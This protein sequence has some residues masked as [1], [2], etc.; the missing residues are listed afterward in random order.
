MPQHLEGDWCAALIFR[1]PV[2]SPSDELYLCSAGFRTGCNVGLQTHVC[3]WMY[4][5]SM[6]PRVSPLDSS[7]L[8]GIAPPRFG[9]VHIRNRGRLPHWEKEAGLYFLTFHLA[10]SLP[11]EVLRKIAERHEI[12]AEAKRINARLL[13]EQEAQ[14]AEYSRRRIEEYVDRGYGSAILADPR[15]AGATTATLRYWADKR[16]RLLAWCVMPNYVHVV[17][18]LFP[19]YELGTIVKGWKH[20]VSKAVNHALGQS[21]KLWQREYYDHLI[22]DGE[23]RKRAIQYVIEN[24]TKAGLKNWSWVCGADQEAGPKKDQ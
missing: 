14:L 13:P 2:A 24:P 6:A 3:T 1:P 4:I 16:Y 10:D 23:E 21:G 17:I 11:K 15:I 9:E 12:L 8:S 19:G 5:L 7:S 20:H 18:R 22:R